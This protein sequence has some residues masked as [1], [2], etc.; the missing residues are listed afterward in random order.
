VSGA[1]E[2]ALKSLRDASDA[3]LKKLYLKK[4][5]APEKEE[6][7]STENELSEEDAELL[8]SLLKE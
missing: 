6:D 4:K 1:L 8:S 2:Q 5:E 3:Q 7:P